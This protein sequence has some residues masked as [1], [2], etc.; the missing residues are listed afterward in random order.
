MVMVMV[1]VKMI[2]TKC[3]EKKIFLNNFLSLLSFNYNVSLRQNN[4][5]QIKTFL[6]HKE[7]IH[8]STYYRWQRGR[9]WKPLP[10]LLPN[11][12]W[13]SSSTT[14]QNNTLL[15]ATSLTITVRY[16]S[17]VKGY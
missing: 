11:P 6:W 10:T 14:S 3:T 8:I 13:N 9:M 5:E 16:I 1:T 17:R 15:C 2:D 7:L 4:N 12:P